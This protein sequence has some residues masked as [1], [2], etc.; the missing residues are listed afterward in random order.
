MKK[1]S[2]N[3]NTTNL[4]YN[5]SIAVMKLL[6]M[7]ILHFTGTMAQWHSDSLSVSDSVVGLK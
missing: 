1:E 4:T 7:M 3:H 6:I 2:Y 5:S